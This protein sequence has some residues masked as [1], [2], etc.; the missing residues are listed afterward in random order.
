MKSHQTPSRIENLVRSASDDRVAPRPLRAR[1]RVGR[2]ARAL[3]HA[4]GCASVAA[5]HRGS[6]PTLCAGALRCVRQSP[7]RPAGRSR[8]SIFGSVR[9]TVRCA[10]AG[11]R[12]PPSSSRPPCGPGCA[13]RAVC[14]S[15]GRTGR[16]PTTTR[17]SAPSAPVRALRSGAP[18]CRCRL[19]PPMPSCASNA[20]SRSRSCRGRP[21]LDEFRLAARTSRRLTTRL[22]ADMLLEHG[23]NAASRRLPA[24][25]ASARTRSWRLARALRISASRTQAPRPLGVPAV[26]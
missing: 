1:N 2:P 17:S 10:S 7:D 21:G 15:A 26:S 24:A 8:S 16:V 3:P 11:W 4:P 9:C 19:R 6:I 23:R 5:L 20:A 22:R 13:W 14:G 12:R 18:P 25:P